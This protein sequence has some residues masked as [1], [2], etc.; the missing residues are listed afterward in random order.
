MPEPQNYKNHARSHPPFHFFLLPIMI[1]NLIVTIVLLIRSWP[2]HVWLH[3]WLVVMALALF[4]QHG[5][6]PAKWPRAVREA[7]SLND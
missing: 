6:E 1:I 7:L 2:E 4:V 3:A 5:R